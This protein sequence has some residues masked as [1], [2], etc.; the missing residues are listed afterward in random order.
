MCTPQMVCSHKRIFMCLF[1]CITTL[2][3]Y[4]SFDICIHTE[5]MTQMLF[6]LTYFIYL[7]KYYIKEL[8]EIKVSRLIFN[9]KCLLMNVDYNTQPSQLTM[10][11]LYPLPA[12]ILFLYIFYSN[13]SSI[14]KPH[15]LFSTCFF[16]IIICRLSST[17]LRSD[18]KMVVYENKMD[19]YSLTYIILLFKVF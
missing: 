18:I 5:R 10:R 4:V 14:I 6:F 8:N 13:K 16:S 9:Q 19:I 1:L 11:V 12:Y 3:L 17:R 15:P 7:L 2:P